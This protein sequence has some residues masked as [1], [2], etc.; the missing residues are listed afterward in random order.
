[1]SNAPSPPTLVR[2]ALLPAFVREER[3]NEETP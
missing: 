1:M 2:R 3:G